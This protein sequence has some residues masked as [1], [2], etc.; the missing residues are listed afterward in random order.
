LALGKEPW[1]FKDL[2][3]QINVYRQQWQADQQKQII[4]Q[5][6]GKNPNKSNEGKRK[7][8]DR[9]HHNSNGGRSSTRQGNNNRGGRGGRG[10]GRGGRGGRTNNSEHLQNVECFNCGKKGH[11]STDCSLPRKNNNENSNVVSKADFKNLFQSSLKDMLTKKEKNNAE[12][13]DDSLDMNV[14]KKL[15]EGKQQMF[16]NKNND[17]LISINDTDTFDYSIQDK[18]TQKSEHNNYNNDYDELAYPFSKR[19]KLKH[20]PEKAQE[21]VPVQYTA[22][23]IVEIKNRD[24]TVVPMRALLDTGTTA[25]IILGEFVGKGRACK[26]TKKRAKWKTLGGTFT[27]NYELLLDFKFPEISTSKVVTWQAHVYDKTSSKEA[28][29]DMIMGM[30]LMTSI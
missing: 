23:I 14:F 19:I 20:E 16:V 2:E 27:T 29:Y 4:A 12:G 8:S 5:M 26:N 1:R 13:D 28:A 6:A 10:R 7:N 22:D 25:T 3:D 30:D 18:I 11:Y 15:M 24:G 21:N 17:D 9:N